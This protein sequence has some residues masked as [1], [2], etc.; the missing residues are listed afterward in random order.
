MDTFTRADLERIAKAH[1]GACISLYMPTKRGGNDVTKE[2]KLRFR[3]L[4]EEAEEMMDYRKLQASDTLQKLKDYMEQGELQTPAGRG[5]AVFASQHLFESY[6]LPIE[7]NERCEVN[8]RFLITPLIGAVDED[9][10]FFLV[11][12][13]RNAVRLFD[14]SKYSLN[15][16]TGP[17]LPM[18][19]DETL[20]YDDPE[21]QL[22]FHTRTQ[23]PSGKRDAVH[24]GHG[25]SDV[26]PK[27]RLH[28]F[29]Q[30]TSTIL[31]EH[32]GKGNRPLIAAGVDYVIP[33]FRDAAHRPGLVSRHISGNPED[34]TGEELHSKAL[35]I[36]EE[37]PE[38]AQRARAR[39]ILEERSGP[40]SM[41]LEEIVPAARFGRVDSLFIVPS[42]DRQGVVHPENAKVER[43]ED[44]GK[45]RDLV[46]EAVLGVLLNSGH[47]F[48]CEPGE[49]PGG[50]EMAAVL[51]Y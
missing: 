47:V 8:D 11:T 2:N 50:G 29:F 6:Q 42:L 41:L 19:I 36:M 7:F 49:V 9:K 14:G 1:N 16:I 38:S 45:S 15:E 43:T 39:R 32:I 10:H 46:N 12:L 25:G 33:I 26:D 13:S 31:D 22:Q 20:W 37:I 18:S 24:H 35:E 27:E 44:T 34:L 28:R 51:R 40:V 4:L 48:T 5:L 21:K 17:D 23:S 30:E 3:H